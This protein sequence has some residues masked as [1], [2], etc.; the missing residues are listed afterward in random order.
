MTRTPNPNPARDT[1]TYQQHLKNALKLFHQLEELGT[2]S[3][4][5]SPY[6]LGSALAAATAEALS[7]RHR[8]ERLQA[9]L[10]EA[11][12]ALLLEA[13]PRNRLAME[14]LL[15]RVRHDPD[16][17][18]YSYLVLELRCFQRF[19]KVS[20]TADIWEREE[21]L[22]GS[23]AE[24]YRDFDRAVDLLGEAL[25]DRLRPNIR[26]EPIV[27]PVRQIGY[28]R[29][30]QRAL[31]ALTA[32]KTVTICGAGGMGKSTLGA[33]LAAAAH[34][35]A[36]FWYT[37]RSGFNDNLQSLLFALAH[38]LYEQGAS[39]LWRQLAIGQLHER[40]LILGLLQ[41]DLQTLNQQPLLLCFDEM[42]ILHG[43]RAGD[44]AAAQELLEFL[45]T[46]QG[47]F[48]MLYI[49]QVPLLES[50]L[51]CEL[52]GL[53]MEQFATLLHNE[54][55]RLA[56]SEIAA[57]HA[58][59]RG[60]PRLLQLALLAL[61]PGQ[62]I[63]ALA[64]TLP[65]TPA[66][67]PIWQRIR[68]RLTLSELQI[69]QQLAIFRRAAPQDHWQEDQAILAHLLAQGL[70][71][72]DSYGGIEVLPVLRDLL[73]QQIDN[74][75]RNS[76]HLNA[77]AICVGRGDYTEAAYHYAQGGCPATAVQSWYPHH[78]HEVLRGQAG[79]ALNIFVQIQPA[80]LPRA[81]QKALALILAELQQRQGHPQQ[82]L[83]VLEEVS[84]EAADEVTDK[85]DDTADVQAQNLRGQFLEALGRISEAE[86]S[87]GVGIQT[88]MRLQQNLVHLHCQRGLLH[89]RRRHTQQMRQYLL[90]ARWETQRLQGMIEEFEGRFQEA[91]ISYQSALAIAQSTGNHADLAVI[92]F[93]LARILTRL[94]HYAEAQQ[95]AQEALT[96]CEASSDWLMRAQVYANLAA[97]HKDAGHHDA[98][99]EVGRQALSQ[100]RMMNSPHWIGLTAVNLAEAYADRAEWAHAERYAEE[101]LAQQAPHSYPYGLFTLGRVRQA[102]GRSAE[103]QAHF[104]RSLDTAHENG[105]RFLE[106]YAQR[107][108]GELC[109]AAGQINE[110]HRYLEQALWLFETV[111]M[112][113]EVATTN[114]L[115]AQNTKEQVVS[116]RMATVA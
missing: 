115:L 86:A 5:A 42:E 44:A 20:K 113:E 34:F 100:F 2:E 109:V 61:E 102:Q 66:I 89:A 59:T 114:R 19:F 40:H 56:P 107:A 53:A 24:H 13:P 26:L 112:V 7:P 14:Q 97:I 22:P 11:A 46:L 1:V 71:Q 95:A 78:T 25:L 70:V 12:A 37:L 32:R 82:G 91:Q 48:A 87:Y 106:A 81:E 30:Y 9:E 69:L 67:Q 79:A 52:R 21:L 38:F 101:A 27:R 104:Q 28:E 73:Y 85:T 50:D 111:G 75:V 23:R 76:L 43:E 99:L 49:S 84:W 83:D 90:Q 110:G 35:T 8:G 98:A 92:Q 62:T 88:L 108:I 74:G 17:H 6:F 54:E 45:R 29:D 16:N 55:R 15:N 80:M 68:Q 31:E 96:H 77:A 105:D 47:H 33:N 65:Q 116:Q 93:A 3:P 58:H 94:G 57:L 18:G 4:L 51:Y 39:A 103:A 60:N 63:G 41:K 36:V 10:L 72:T 64:Q